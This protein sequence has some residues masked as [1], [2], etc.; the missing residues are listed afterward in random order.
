MQ[1]HHEEAVIVVQGNS[2]S[3]L[4]SW[5]PNQHVTDEAFKEFFAEHRKE[6]NR[7][8]DYSKTP[9]NGKK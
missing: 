5:K 3:D 4:P 6:R 1:M 8:D 9:L 2:E 7:N